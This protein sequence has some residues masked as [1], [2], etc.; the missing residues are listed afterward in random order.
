MIGLIELTGM[1]QLVLVVAELQKALDKVPIC[2]KNIN[3]LYEHYMIVKMVRINLTVVLPTV[4]GSKVNSTP[5][6]KIRSFLQNCS[7]C[8]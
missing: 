8:V 3:F 4:P 1:G 6:S 7:L 5:C 2:L